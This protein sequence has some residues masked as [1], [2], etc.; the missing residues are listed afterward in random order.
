MSDMPEKDAL[1]EFRFGMELGDRVAAYLAYGEDFEIV[2][3]LKALDE[4]AHT[5]VALAGFLCAWSRIIQRQATLISW[6][7]TTDDR[8]LH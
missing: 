2:R 7:E 3:L 5:E 4:S 8:T 6:A 1:D